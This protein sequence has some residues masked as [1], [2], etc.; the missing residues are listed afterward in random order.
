M[1]KRRLIRA[2]FF[3]GVAALV[4]ACTS[5]GDDSSHE[6]I[7]QSAAALSTDVCLG[8]ADTP[9]L[10]PK[11]VQGYQGR[12]PS[13]QM[14]SGTVQNTDVVDIP[15]RID[16]R[17]A[18][19]DARVISSTLWQGTLPRGSTQTVNLRLDSLP[20]RSYRGV[21]SVAE[22]VATATGAARRGDVVY[23]S[24]LYA[25]YDPAAGTFTL[26]GALPPQARFLSTESTFGAAVT[27][28]ANRVEPI[29]RRAGGG[30][31]HRAQ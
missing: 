31:A 9:A 1:I 29:T 26:S 3:V 4:V 17:M 7:G 14:I 18:G 19:G 24:P 22:I 28:V 15:V 5:I 20:I 6:H 16:V 13:S 27:Q 25:T 8:G 12:F 10:L 21:A 11:W 2:S 30:T 23:S